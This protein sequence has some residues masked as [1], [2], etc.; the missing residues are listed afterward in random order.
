MLRGCRRTALLAA[1]IFL[2]TLCVVPTEAW[3][4][5]TQPVDFYEVL[6]LGDLREEAT[7]KQIKKNFRRLSK[8]Y[9]PDVVKTDQ[10]RTKYVDVN[11]AY[12]VLTDKRKRKLYDMRGH[13]GLELLEKAKMQA[14]GNDG[15][16]LF[17]HFFGRQ[18]G[19]AA[20]GLQGSPMKEAI[21]VPLE[22]VFTGGTSELTFHKQI[23]CKKCRGSGAASSGFVRCRH[24]S[25]TGGQIHHVMI[26]PGMYQEV[27]QPCPACRGSGRQPKNL[28]PHCNGQRVH[29]GTSD[30]V[31]EV[32]Q[33]IPEGHQVVFE[34]EGSES[35]DQIP[36]DVILSVHT[37]PHS[38]FSRREN[39]VDLEVTFMISLKEA[40]LGFKRTFKHLD[41]I[42]DVVV[43]ETGINAHGTILRIPMKGMPKHHVPSER[44]DLFINI[45]VIMPPMITDSMRAQLEKLLE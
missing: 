38:R 23:L 45:K 6:D 11:R 4:R 36:G 43:H 8:K 20:N 10:D 25:G 41:M 13:E 42:E 22:T 17:N 32:E 7:L 35:P 37:S 15:D 44:G 21:T 5:Y 1:G 27:R 3:G 30:I 33:G 29:L 16:T 18:A 12:E 39:N 14:S 24:C 19:G 9:H 40:L 28:C 2:L 26:Q 31:L 34:M